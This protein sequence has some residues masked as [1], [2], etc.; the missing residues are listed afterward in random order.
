MDRFFVAFIIDAPWPQSFPN[1][2]LLVPHERHLTIAFL[3]KSNRAQTLKSFEALSTQKLPTGFCGCFDSI[4]FLPEKSPRVVAYHAQTS[5]EDELCEFVRNVN[6]HMNLVLSKQW[7][8]HVTIGRSP[9]NKKE[10]EKSFQPLPF[11][12]S[13]FGLFESLGNLRYKVLA[14]IPL[15]PAIEKLD[16]TADLAYILRGKTL[17]ELFH[18]AIVSLSF[19]DLHFLP[20]L[21]IQRRFASIDEI[22]IELNRLIRELDSQ[23]GCPFKAVSFHDTLRKNAGFYEWEMIIDV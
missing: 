20:F 22:I 13:S 16:H 3:G 15:T 9:F 10:W 2:R 19:D 21:A 17:E 12:V 4:I 14:E 7:M 5:N 6:Q 1:A 11:C 8:P 23:H 18:H